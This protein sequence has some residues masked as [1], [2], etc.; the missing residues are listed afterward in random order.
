LKLYPNALLMSVMEWAPD[1][2]IAESMGKIKIHSTLFV[3]PPTTQA[4]TDHLCALNFDG[5]R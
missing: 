5:L 3:T 1:R 4:T 2:F